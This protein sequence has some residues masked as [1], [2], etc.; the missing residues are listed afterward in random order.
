MNLSNWRSIHHS[1]ISTPQPY[2]SPGQESS[3]F[4]SASLLLIAS[5]GSAEKF[6]F[7]EDTELGTC[8]FLSTGPAVGLF[9][10]VTFERIILSH[11]VVNI[12]STAYECKSNEVMYFVLYS[13]TRWWHSVVHHVMQSILSAIFILPTHRVATVHHKYTTYSTSL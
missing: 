8:I 11:E 6:S 5:S 3:V 1:T 2:A 13:L 9:F 10:W 7:S 12:S 4:S